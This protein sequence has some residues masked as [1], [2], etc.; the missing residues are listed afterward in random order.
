MQKLY[1]MLDLE[2]LDEPLNACLNSDFLQVERQ[3]S[4]NV[5]PETLG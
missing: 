4:I 2:D 5:L 3:E 1:F